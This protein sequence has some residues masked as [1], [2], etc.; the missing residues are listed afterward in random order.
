MERF[1]TTPE[2]SYAG[3]IALFLSYYGQ[4]LAPDAVPAPKRGGLG[5]LQDLLRERYQL[6]TRLVRLGEVLPETAAIVELSDGRFGV[7]AAPTGQSSWLLSPGQ[8]ALG[9]ISSKQRTELGGHD[10][11]LPALMT[12]P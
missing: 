9:P 11:L 8:R 6:E 5:G 2:Q 1:Y 12:N 10:A 3:A 7:L 4:E